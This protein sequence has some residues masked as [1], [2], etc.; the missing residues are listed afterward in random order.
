MK[1]LDLLRAQRA[2]FEQWRQAVVDSIDA[3]AT[4]A[5]D[6]KRS[7][8]AEEDAELDRLRSHVGDI[9]NPEGEL[10]KLNERIGELE[11]VEERTSAIAA[12]PEIHQSR[13]P[14]PTDV[15]ED[16]MAGATA[17]TDALR[18]TLD[19][20]VPDTEMRAAAE[21]LIVRHGTD[22]R[23]ARNL[24]ARSTPIYREAFQK[25]LSNP[26]APAWTSEEA[27]AIAIGTNTQ[28]G[29]LSPTHLD[30]TFIY[31]N[32]GTDNAIRQI[33]RVVTLT[34]GDIWY[35]VTTAG[36][37]ASWDAE[38]VEV[39]DDS[40]ALDTT[41]IP[42]YKG[43]VFVAASIEAVQDINGL[44]SGLRDVMRDAK[45]RLEAAAFATGTGSGQPTG[46]FTALDANTNVE[47]ISTTAAVIGEVDIH[48]VYRQL[49]VR[50]RGGASWL[51]HPLYSLAVKRLGTAVSS[52]YSG[53]LREAPA[54]RWLGRPVYESDD[55]PTTQTTTANDNEIV[56]GDF[57][58]FVIVDK[59]GSFS[60]E[61]IPHVFSGSNGRPIGARGWY[62]WWR[63]GS[64]S[65]NDLAFRLLQDKT[66]A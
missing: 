5:I 7:L 28:G 60:V 47:I 64:D 34:E 61:Y 20:L 37:S 48:S 44:E 49:G 35:G 1:Y 63:T 21:R 57:R 45:D 38:L 15:L 24:L 58:N 59:P 41:S 32:T 10:A 51:T 8:N 31:T 55:A 26:M 40:P 17:V 42:V 14:D 39:S 43:A 62:G 16:R 27:R 11:A 56:F 19:T 33:S 50:W 29:F 3:L 6:E 23:W 2:E 65:V 12:R 9:D 13:T 25:Y 53:D 36:A 22:E 30:P 54:E 18:S 66:S 52:S 46:I 4:T